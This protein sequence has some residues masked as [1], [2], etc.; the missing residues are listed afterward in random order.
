MR[1][2]PY[3]EKGAKPS[4]HME[5]KH[6]RAVRHFSAVELWPMIA[7]KRKRDDEITNEKKH[8]TKGIVDSTARSKACR[9]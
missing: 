3:L 2:K 5:C 8:K 7:A 1:I 9:A 6:V 4:V